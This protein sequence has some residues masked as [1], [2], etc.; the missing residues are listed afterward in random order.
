MKESEFSLEDQGS[1]QVIAYLTKALFHTLVTA[2]DE[3]KKIA[4]PFGHRLVTL[5]QNLEWCRWNDL[6]ASR[7]TTWMYVQK[8]M[9]G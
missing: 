4:P 6:T 5:R 3:A 8:A 7:N 1:R 2:R 9:A